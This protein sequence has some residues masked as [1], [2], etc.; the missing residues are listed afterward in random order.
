MSPEKRKNDVKVLDES[1]EI[2]AA[3][4]KESQDYSK[5]NKWLT[6]SL[7]VDSNAAK[8]SLTMMDSILDEPDTTKPKVGGN[9]QA[10]AGKSGLQVNSGGGLFGP[11]PFSNLGKQF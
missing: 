6:K 9:A 7:G 10:D 4:G 11:N 8:E 1:K 2:E 5:I 3:G